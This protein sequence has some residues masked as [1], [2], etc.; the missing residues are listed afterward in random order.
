MQEDSIKIRGRIVAKGQPCYIVAEA[1]GNA[2]SNVELAISLVEKAKWAGADAIK[3]QTYKA[4]ILATKKAPKYWVDT[5]DEWEKGVKPYGCQYDEFKQLDGLTIHDY[6]IIKKKCDELDITFFST[7]FDFESVD[8]LSE[9]EVSVYKI[10]SADITYFDLLEYIGKKGK[11]I[12]LST[13]ASTLNEVKEAV[14]VIKGTGNEQ[15]ILLQCTLHYPCKYDE[16]HINTMKTLVSEFPEH[17][18]GLSD[19]SL[20]TLVPIVAAANGAQVI[21]KHFTIDKTLK[22][23]TDHFISVDP[24]E[25]KE[26]VENIKKIP[27]IMGR[28]IKQPDPSE[29]LARLYARRSVTTTKKINK[30]E[31][32]TEE[33][34]MCRR[35]ETGISPVHYRDILFKK[36][37]VD[38]E[39]EYPLEWNML[40]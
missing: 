13:G 14:N 33:N 38:I 39:E 29:E 19:H 15:I 9:L 1:G 2:N 24:E 5:M 36:A 28:S 22:Q 20:G 27:D 11:P 40:E 31:L 8:L 6:K 37:K 25:L 21:E 23:S 35:S 17:V 7:P 4:N 26:M 12:I 18:I 10:A 32:L 30:G 34:T 3:F 16:V